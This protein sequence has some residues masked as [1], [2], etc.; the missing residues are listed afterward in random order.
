[1]APGPKPIALE[2]TDRERAALGEIVRR[3]NVG[4]ALAQRARVVLACAAP[5]ATNLGVAKALGVSRP[6]VATWRRRFAA[7]RLEGLVDAP[8][9]G[10]PRTIGDEAVERLVALTLEEAPAN[11]THWSTR[12]M[13]KRAGMS[14]TAVSRIW[15]AFG[16]RPHRVET[17]KLSSDP[18]FV[19]KVRDVVGLYLA[20]P[21]RALVLCVDEK[22]QIQAVERTAPVLPLRPGEPERR[23]HDHKRHGTTDLF[24]ALDVK[25]GTLIG[26]CK[27]RH[28]A[29]EFRAFLDQVEAAVPCDLDVHLVLDNAATPKARLVHDWLVK[30]PRFHLHFTPTGASWLNLVECWFA[31][32]SR[33]R[34]ERGVFTSTRELEEAILAYIAETNA[35]PKPFV[36]TKTADAIL[37]SVA[38]FC[39]RT[40]NSDH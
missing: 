22:P 33:R 34:L 6:T 36:W 12:S 7:H 8:R 4:Q 13:A 3:R 24:A 30:R 38:R 23:S 29:L 2:L 14:Q 15:R 27:R 5:G 16:L 19:A 37:A 31:V 1:M 40:S 9:P 20:P 25:A 32:L 18:A 35:D 39:Q 21:D 10:A 17:F 26:A 11:A 28:R